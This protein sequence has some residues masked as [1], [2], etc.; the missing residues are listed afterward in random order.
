[1]D[2]LPHRKRNRLLTVFLASTVLAAL[3]CG[4]ESVPVES[5]RPI[6]SGVRI[7]TLAPAEVEDGFDATGTVRA[8]RTS[9]IA[10]R[11][12]GV[13]TSVR[14]REGDMVK[15]GQILIT[16]D[17]RDASEREKAASLA[18]AAAREQRDLAEAT[19]RRHRNLYDQKAL[20][21]QEMDQVSAQ[22]KVAQSE[23]ARA[24]AIAAE[25]R[26]YRGFTRITA[27][28]AGRVVERRVDEGSMASPGMPLMVLESGGSSLIEAAVDESL[29]ARVEI[30]QNVSVTVEAL[31][32]RL[33]G[34]IREILP[35]VDPATR[36][37]TIKI[38][39]NDDRLKSGLFARV[40]IPLGKR[41]A[42]LIPESALVTKG[43]LTG[44]YVV[45]AGGVVTYR[46]IRTGARSSRGVEVLS[47]LNAHER[48]ITAGVEK[49]MDGGRLAKGQV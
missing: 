7:T 37:F 6:I 38:A 35:S 23:Y 25:A 13:I 48:I 15:P 36:T 45:D 34:I 27:P 29:S 9:V 17:D 42:L 3:G 49:A 43:V 44:V 18:V 19:W 5:E 47:G 4:K 1:M 24:L 31:N 14:V 16:V 41:T 20:S 2:N 11:V 46:L 30:G 26:T 39:V 33:A 8:E 21:D 10:S 22:R 32:V 28:M 12:M 40:R